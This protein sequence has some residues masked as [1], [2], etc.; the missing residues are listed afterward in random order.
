[1]SV[2]RFEVTFRGADGDYVAR[3]VPGLDDGGIEVVILGQPMRWPVETLEETATGFALSGLTLG[4]KPLWGDVYWFVLQTGDVPRVE[5]WADRVLI[6][7][8]LGV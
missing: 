1:M 7:S 4:S 3:Y 2:D 8:D 5:Y 6:R